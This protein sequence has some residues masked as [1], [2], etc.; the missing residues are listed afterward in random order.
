MMFGTKGIIKA[1]LSTASASVSVGAGSKPA[2]PQNSLSL[3][4]RVG[5][6]D[7]RCPRTTTAFGVWLLCIAAAPPSLATE[8]KV[9][10]DHEAQVRAWAVPKLPESVPSAGA[11]FVGREFSLSIPDGMAQGWLIVLDLE[12]GNVAYTAWDGALTLWNVKQGDWRIAEVEVRATYENKPASGLAVLRSQGRESTR[13]LGGGS[14]T[15]FGIAPGDVSV[16]VRYVSQGAQHE[17]VPQRFQ[18]ELQRGEAKP[19][20]QVS[21]PQAPDDIPAAAREVTSEPSKS[22]QTPSGARKWLPIFIAL[23]VGVAAL[24]ALYQLLKQHE[25]R[26]AE[27]LRRL[28]V[29]LPSSGPGATAADWGAA[30]DDGATGPATPATEPITEGIEPVAPTGGM[31]AAPRATLRLVGE[32]ISLDLPKDGEYVVGRDPTCD[33][34]IADATV[35]RRHATLY[36]REGTLSVRDEGSTNGTYLNGAR[37]EPSTEHTLQPGDKLQFGFVKLRVE[38]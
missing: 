38:S 2:L 3:W 28:G 4:E 36:V 26:V 1:F 18:L 35:S 33:F 7:R 10:L 27:S 11:E 22:A 24:V 34:A 29:K 9:L 8:V 14:A 16:L 30:P 25:D 12:L 21:L 17:T 31:P 37:I 15:F 5:V 32:S 13:L 6:R 20:L 19:V 23:V